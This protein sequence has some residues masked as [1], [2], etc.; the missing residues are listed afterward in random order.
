MLSFSSPSSAPNGDYSTTGLQ[1]VKD[2]V[3]INL[4]DEVLQELGVVSRNRCKDGSTLLLRGSLNANT[5][6]SL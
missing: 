2:V 1:G 5:L 4:F 6:L 3:F